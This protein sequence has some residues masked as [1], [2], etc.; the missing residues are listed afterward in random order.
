MRIFPEK[1]RFDPPADQRLAWDTGSPCAGPDPITPMDLGLPAE[2][3]PTPN[4][5]VVG[6][7]LTQLWSVPNASAVWVDLETAVVIY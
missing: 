7:R 2:S 1:V 6:G 4:L 3:Q 5:R